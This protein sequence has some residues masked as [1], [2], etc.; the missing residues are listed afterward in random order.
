MGEQPVKVTMA[1]VAR[2][3]DVSRTT[4]SFVLNDRQGAAIP[5]ETRQKVRDAARRIGYRPN[6]S[7]R[8][9][10]SRRTGIIGMV[11]EIVTGPFAAET[12]VGAQYAAHEAGSTLFIVASTGDADHDH[13]AFATMLEHRVEG[14]IY[15]T[16]SHR[17][18]RL[19]AEADEVPTV[20]V[21]CFEPDGVTRRARALPTILP[22]EEQAGR[23]ATTVLL[24][25]GRTRVGLIELDPAIPASVGRRAGYEAAL[26]SA[27]LP[28][29]PVLIEVGGATADGGYRAASTLLDLD[30]PPTALFC[31]NDRMAMGAY[32]AIK[33]RGLRVGEDVVVVGIDN[34]EL[35]ATGLR[36]DLSTVAL[37]F[38]EMGQ[39]AIATI[40]ALSQ[41]KE[42]EAVQVLPCPLV[43]RHSA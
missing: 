23:L 19:P 31:A 37:P 13:R 30:A 7:A 24:E 28:V 33:E 34:Q 5:E 22:D 39:A 2:A 41:G 40:G 18:V 4:V 38:A 15:A 26:E 6:A 25:S 21:H 20:L 29:D 12:V 9:L 16:G 3:A 42:V 11:T 8:A 10:A 14:I 17:A 43:R 1:D 36:P 32:D 27:G 35:I